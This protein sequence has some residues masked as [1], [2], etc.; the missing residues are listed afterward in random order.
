M[1]VCVCVYT[2]LCVCICVCDSESVYFLYAVLYVYVSLYC[3]M[4]LGAY[5]YL[6]LYVYICIC[7]CVCIFM[8]LIVPLL[9]LECLRHRLP[10]LP[11]K[12]LNV[13]PCLVVINYFS[14]PYIARRSQKTKQVNRFINP[15]ISFCHQGICLRLCYNRMRK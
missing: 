12:F 13:V 8:Q 7:M 11:S 3:I 9:F 14:L 15:Q 2:C 10:T 1:C 5:I 4:L 6:S